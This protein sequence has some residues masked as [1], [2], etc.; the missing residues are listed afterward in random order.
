MIPKNNLYLD[1]AL[2]AFT[3]AENRKVYLLIKEIPYV[4]VLSK[5]KT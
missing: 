5:D 2:K 4:L 1:V 3:T